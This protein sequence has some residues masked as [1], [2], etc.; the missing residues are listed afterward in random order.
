MAT[1]ATTITPAPAPRKKRYTLADLEPIA[2]PWD[3]TRYEIVDGELFVATQPSWQHQSVSYAVLTRLGDW[4]ERSGR[5]VVRHTPGLIFADDDNA[6]PD[7]VWLTKQR[8]RAILRDDGKLHGAP[9]LVV[10]IL[11]PGAENERRDREAKPRLYSRRGV[12]EYWILDP[13]RDRR[14]VYRRHPDDPATLRLAA[15]LGPE[16]ALESPLLPGFAAGV[17]EL[18]TGEDDWRPRRSWRPGGSPASA[19]QRPPAGR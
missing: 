1:P 16:E 5:G 7:V 12:D 15:V 6:A 3:D 13:Q 14:E 8:L 9:E 11:S 18:F 4:S 10:E 2:Q 19:P 17:A